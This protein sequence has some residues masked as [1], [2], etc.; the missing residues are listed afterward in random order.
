[1]GTPDFA[2]PILETLIQNTNVVLVVSQPD[3]KVG[4]KQILTKTPIHEVADKYGISVFQPEKIK[5]DYERILEVKPDIIITCA[6]GQ[7]I[8]KVLLDLPRL[9]CINV[10]ASL[11]PKLRGGAPLHH[12]II[13]GLDKTGVTIMYMDEAMDTGDIISTISYDIKSSDTTEDIHD[14]LRELGAKLLIDTLPSI[15]TGTNRRIKQNETEATYGYNITREEEH[16]DFNKSGILI[17]RLVRG[18]YSWPLANTIIGDT[19]YKIVAGYFVKGKGNPGMISDISKK[20]LGIGCLDGTYYVTKI[21]PAGKKIMDI[22]D[23]LNGIDIEEFK[24]RSIK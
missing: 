5:N 18:L 19:E 20:V 4:R 14:T 9:G 23:F 13:D 12:A 11:L 10:H 6:Y 3:K 7:I 21:K 2:V 22:K 24:S 8:P 1:M 15:V 17:D 16:I